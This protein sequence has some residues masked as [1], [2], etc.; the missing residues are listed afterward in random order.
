MLPKNDQFQIISRSTPLKVRVVSKIAKLIGVNMSDP[1]I[2]IAETRL[3]QKRRELEDLSDISADSRDAVELDQ[4]SVGRLSRMDALQQQAMSKATELKR[5]RD[6]VRIEAAE[7]RIRD[8]E[9]GYCEE[10]GEPIPDKRL[11]IDPMAERC[12]SCAGS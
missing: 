7:R 5:Q 12:V 10:C 6:L 4:Q 1:D 11:D 8:D 9:Y 3:R 2:A